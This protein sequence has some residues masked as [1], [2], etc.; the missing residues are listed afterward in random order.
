MVK[1]GNHAADEMEGRGIL[2][3]YIEAALISPDRIA[4]DVTDPALSHS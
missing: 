2:F 4:Q 1:L 3:S